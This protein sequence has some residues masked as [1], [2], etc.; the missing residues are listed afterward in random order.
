MTL[1]DFKH[2]YINPEKHENTDAY[3]AK[4][5]MQILN[6]IYSDSGDSIMLEREFTQLSTAQVARLFGLKFAKSLNDITQGSWQGPVSSGYGLHLVKIDKKT[7]AHV[8]TL[9]EMEANVKRDYRNDAQKKAIDSFYEELKTQY[10]VTV[11]QE[12]Q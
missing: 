11:A 1:Y 7:P 12:V 10:T 5:K 2:I 8:A 4:L 3:I 6:N 9:D